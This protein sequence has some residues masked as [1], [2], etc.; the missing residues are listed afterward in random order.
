MCLVEDSGDNL[1]PFA[2]QYQERL[3]RSV[4]ITGHHS[5]SKNTSRVMPASLSV[6][7]SVSLKQGRASSSPSVNIFYFI[8]KNSTHP[9]WINHHIRIY[10]KQACI[11]VTCAVSGILKCVNTFSWSAKGSISL[12]LTGL[13]KTSSVQLLL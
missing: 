1:K 12:T 4:L 13:L 5:K 3:S 2:W 10:W 6:R 11:S 9:S 7:N 8:T